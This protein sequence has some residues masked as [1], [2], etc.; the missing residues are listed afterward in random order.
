MDDLQRARIVASK[1]RFR[2]MNERIRSQVDG[3][4]GAVDTYSLMCE[5]AL[6]N[7]QD[8]LELSRGDYDRVRS[9]ISWFVVLPDHMIP[10]A[11]KVVEQNERF[12][13][14]EGA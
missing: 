4:D 1:A 14:I 8:M 5:C 10:P 2:A 3:F 11:E 13:I 12:W 6:V 9:V 7:C